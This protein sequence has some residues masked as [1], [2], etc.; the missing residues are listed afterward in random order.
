MPTHWIVFSEKFNLLN[1]SEDHPILYT[2]IPSSPYY[3]PPR[4]TCI[5]NFRPIKRLCRSFGSREPRAK[6]THPLPCLNLITLTLITYLFFFLL[7]ACLACLRSRTLA[8]TTTITI[9]IARVVV[10]C[11]INILSVVSLRVFGF[12]KLTRAA[13]FIRYLYLEKICLTCQ[14]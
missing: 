8:L 3:T 10:L 4:D 14:K 6:G 5:I 13:K 1:P 2:C 9:A 7:F 12:T 11:L